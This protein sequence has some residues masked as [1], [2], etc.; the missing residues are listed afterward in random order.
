MTL[1]EAK[2]CCATHSPI[3]IEGSMLID[4]KFTFIIR[5]NDDS[6]EP[7]VEVE[8]SDQLFPLYLLKRY[9]G[10]TKN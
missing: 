9:F 7:T 2:I 10:S 5:I 8:H 4:R 3:E 1:E 6:V